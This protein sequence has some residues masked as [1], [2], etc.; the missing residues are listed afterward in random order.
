MNSKGLVVKDKYL[1]VKALN[2]AKGL[3]ISGF[4]SSDGLMGNFKKRNNLVC[5]EQTSCRSLPPN[6]KSLAIEFINKTRELIKNFNKTKKIS[7]ILIRCPDIL[8][9]KTVKHLQ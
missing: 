6:V 2:I 8:S 5:R 1:K 4:K 9:R 7:L 3:G